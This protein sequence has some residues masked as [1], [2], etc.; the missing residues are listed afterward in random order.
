M[1]LNGSLSSVLHHQSLAIVPAGAHHPQQF[2]PTEQSH[3]EAKA[4]RSTWSVI[5]TIVGL[6][7]HFLPPGH[8]SLLSS[9][10]HASCLRRPSPS[11]GSQNL[12]GGGVANPRPLNYETRALPTRLLVLD[13]I[14]GKSLVKCIVKKDY[15]LTGGLGLIPGSLQIS[16][17]YYL[18][19]RI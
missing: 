18:R 13:K 15:E 14:G 8:L 1:D 2:G 9:T 5:S 17:T 16:F 19:F 12:P 7:A 6:S 11:N 3:K 4:R 10:D